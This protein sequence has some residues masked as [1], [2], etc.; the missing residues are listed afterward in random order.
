MKNL[1]TI[2]LL[3]VTLASCSSKKN[4]TAHNGTKPLLIKTSDLSKVTYEGGDGK[5]IEKAIIIRNAENS[6]DGIASEYAYIAK[7]HGEKFKDWKPVS[8]S[9]VNKDDKK[10]DVINIEI[11]AK[12]EKLVYYFDITEFYGKF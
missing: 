11:I 9:L 8:Q 7:I 5:S 6:M 1:L 12:E 2:L 4:I 10:I 3:L